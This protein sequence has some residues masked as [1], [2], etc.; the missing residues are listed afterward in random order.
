MIAGSRMNKKFTFLERNNENFINFI[1]RNCCFLMHLKLEVRFKEAFGF[2][3]R[4]QCEEK[5]IKKNRFTVCAANL[6]HCK[7][8]L[9][10]FPSPVNNQ[11]LPGREQ[12]NNSWPGRVWLVTSRLGTRKMITFFTVDWTTVKRFFGINICSR[13][14]HVTKYIMLER[15]LLN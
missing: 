6:R 14:L 10:L 7:K 12:F 2:L 15:A 13:R 9:S 3:V 11:T 1:W 4:S 8:R 5:K